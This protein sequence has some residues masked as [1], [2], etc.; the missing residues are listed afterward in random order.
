MEVSR[1]G[2][3]RETL[4]PVHQTPTDQLST[5]IEKLR[6]AVRD[7]DEMKGKLGTKK[8]TTKL[9]ARL[10]K[11]RADAAA[12][13][14]AIRVAVQK[15]KK[16]KGTQQK[17]VRRILKDLAQVAEAYK[18]VAKETALKERQF[19]AQ[20][21][22]R[23]DCTCA[24]FGCGVVTCLPAL[25][26]TAAHNLAACVCVCVCVCVAV[27]DRTSQWPQARWRRVTVPVVRKTAQTVVTCRQ[28]CEA[29][30][31]CC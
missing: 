29:P 27:P 23:I 8:D 24:C 18:K 1:R 16:G 15:V 30:T 26:P 7:M 14:K 11:R 21:V 6:A 19:R 12:A 20:S 22:R 9:R 10:K 4:N 2:G 17:K 31:L 3:T 28:A 5:D 13:D 25:R